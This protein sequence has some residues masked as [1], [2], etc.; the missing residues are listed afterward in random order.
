[1]V[2]GTGSDCATGTISGGGVSGQIA[3]FSGTNS[4]TS[5]A[6]FTFAT[7]TGVFAVTAT[8][9]FNGKVAIGTTTPTYQLDVFGDINTINN[10]RVN[11]VIIASATGTNNVFLAGAGN[12]TMTGSDNLLIGLSAGASLTGG[13]QN[14]IIGLNAGFSLGN[15][16][17]N[18]FV[19]DYAGYTSNANFNVGVGSGAGYANST[20]TNTSAFG[21]QAGY[22]NKVSENTFLG[23][24]AGYNNTTGNTNLFVGYQAGYL[25]A[26][27]SGI[28]AIGHNAGYNTKKGEN[29]FVGSSAGYTNTTGQYNTAVGYQSGYFNTTGIVNAYLGYQSGYLNATGSYIVAVGNAAGYNNKVD[30]GVFIGNQ[31]GTNNTTGIGNTAVGYQSGY[32]N[33]TG[34]FNVNIGRAAGYSN[35][36]SGGTFIGY[37]AGQTNTTGANNTFV[38]YSAGFS[39]STGTQIALFGTEAGYNLKASKATYL[40]YQSGYDTTTG[41]NNTF[42]GWSSGSSTTTGSDNI[43][44]GSNSTPAATVNSAIII[45]NNITANTSNTVIIGGGSNYNLIVGST[46]AAGADRVLTVVGTS[47][48]NGKLFL[49]NLTAL[50]GAA[51]AALCIVSSTSHEVLEAGG[52][53]C[54]TSSRRYKKNIV[55]LNDGLSIIRSL[56]PVTFNFIEDDREGIGFIAEEINEIDPRLVGFDKLG[57]PDTVE[58]Q[59]ITAYLAKAIQQQQDEIGDIS[60]TAARTVS[61]TYALAGRIGFFNQSSTLISSDG[62]IFD[63]LSASI[64]VGGN[65]FF[66]G[67]VAIG[68][69]STDPNAQVTIIGSGSSTLP[70]SAATV[71]TIGSSDGTATGNSIRARGTISGGLADVGEYAKV[72]GDRSQYAQGDIL[73]VSSSSTETFAKSSRAY[74]EE[75]AGIVTE[76]A[77]LLA[78]GGDSDISFDPKGKSTN[79]VIIALAGRVPVKVSLENGAIKQG[80][81]ITASSKPGVG[82]KQNEPGPTIGRAMEVFD[83][84]SVKDQDG[85]GSVLV[86]VESGFSLGSGDASLTNDSL[87]GQTIDRFTA[88][89]QR[90]LAKLGAVVSDGIARVKQLFAE[91]VTTNKL[92]LDDVCIDKGQLQQIINNQQPS[93]GGSG[94]SQPSNNQ[95]NNGSSSQSG[96]SQT[97]QST[98]ST[99]DSTGQSDASATQNQ[100]PETNTQSTPV[101]QNTETPADQN[102]EPPV[103]STVPATENTTSQDVVVPS[104]NTSEPQS[105]TPPATVE[106]TPDPVSPSESP[107]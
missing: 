90:S 2:S 72:E 70:T 14:T 102:T 30:Q 61:S 23:A 27:G 41:S 7:S 47:T 74:Q 24:S 11:G 75:I 52:Q 9:S 84:Q 12:N 71:V 31:A 3:F 33:A 66:S 17:Y 54:A 55:D 35:K 97:N 67:K 1:V 4:V 85:V 62:L 5:S 83:E 38:G 69:T 49:T 40:G 86:F 88:T 37:D 13:V 36:A 103:E 25:N 32:Q 51:R 29:T 107:A 77:G 16:Q 60:A 53:T 19:G 63:Q 56:R 65:G 104:S 50:G 18:T 21:Y 92:C 91:T 43:V 93:T 78:G 58:Y 46:T 44:L 42:V 105:I 98:Q 79:R 99:G 82:M 26:T 15:A 34:T 64:H 28:T 48:I 57:R 22:N 73:V 89:V 100:V 87:L 68:T 81:Y 101:D 106:P 80:D 8:S 59:L 6:N 20:G 39:N 76:T 45:G 10:Y 94:V 95:E 96:D